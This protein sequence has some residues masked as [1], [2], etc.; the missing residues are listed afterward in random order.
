MVRI[1]MGVPG[2]HT[3]LQHQQPLCCLQG[4][5]I[6]LPGVRCLLLGCIAWLDNIAAGLKRVMRTDYQCSAFDPACLVDNCSQQ[7]LAQLYVI[8]HA[9]GPTFL[10][11]PPSK[12]PPLLLRIDVCLCNRQV[13][14]LSVLLEHGLDVFDQAPD[15]S[16]RVG[17]HGRVSCH[18]CLGTYR[19]HCLTGSVIL[20]WPKRN[21]WLES[22]SKASGR[23]ARPCP[24]CLHMYLVAGLGWTFWDDTC[25]SRHARG[26][27]HQASSSN[28]HYKIN[29]EAAAMCLLRWMLLAILCR[30]TRSLPMLAEAKSTGV[31]QDCVLHGIMWHGTCY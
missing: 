15:V 29:G 31:L 6:Y 18:D 28:S 9:L 12:E 1:Q 13:C 27:L 23:A 20:C 8:V 26:G 25:C 17:L 14:L 7:P 4:Q 22:W 3:P 30:V 16:L 10:P 19:G 5:G 11:Y 2:P 24:S 21:L